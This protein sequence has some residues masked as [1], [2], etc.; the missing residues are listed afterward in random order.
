[1]EPRPRAQAGPHRLRRLNTP[2]PVPVRERSSLPEAVRLRGRWRRLERIAEVWR[3]DDG[4]WRPSP[5]ARTYFRVELEGGQLLTLY[6][7]DGE[8]S[9]WTQRY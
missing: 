7:D 9:W 8:G 2:D 4:W 6:R 1:M 3:V 5:V